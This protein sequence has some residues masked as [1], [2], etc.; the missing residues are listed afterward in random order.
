MDISCISG[1]NT[2][3]RYYDLEYFFSSV[4]KNKLSSVELW[5][6]PQHFFVNNVAYESP[7]K[8]HRLMQKYHITIDCLCPESNNPKPS[9]IAARDLEIISNTKTYY[10][11]VFEIAKEIGSKLVLITPGWNYYDEDPVV[12]RQRSISM[13]KYLCNLASEYD[14]TLTLESIWNKSSQIAPTIECIY[15]IISMVDKSNLKLTLDLGA[16]ASAKETVADW[17]EVFGSEKINHCHFVDGN[18]TGH[19]SWG[20]GERNMQTDLNAFYSNGFNGNF[21]FEFVDAACYRHPEE[22]DKRSIELFQKT[23]ERMERSYD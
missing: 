5:L 11:N 6:C 9:N 3:Y 17:F 20:S 13:I 1:M 16:L 12:A 22:E 19:K 21:S 18:P 2:H 8:L 4:S 7:E 10:K 23:I 14:I 15:E